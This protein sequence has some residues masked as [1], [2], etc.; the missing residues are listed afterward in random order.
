MT[1]ES[2]YLLTALRQWHKELG[3]QETPYELPIGL[4]GYGLQ[5]TVHR[6]GSG[7]GLEWNSAEYDYEFRWDFDEKPQPNTGE[8]IIYNISDDTIRKMRIGDTLITFGGFDS[9]GGVGWFFCA[10]IAEIEA[11]WKGADRAVTLHLTQNAVNPNVLAHSTWYDQGA[12]ADIGAFGSG[13]PYIAC[14]YG[15][16]M[17]ASRIL[18]DLVEQCGYP[19]LELSCESDR[20]YGEAV[21]VEGPLY[22][23]IAEF[24][25]VCGSTAY[26]AN[27]LLVVKNLGV[28]RAADRLLI[29]QQSGL[30]E[31]PTPFS[32]ES[33]AE[34]GPS[35]RGYKVKLLGNQRVQIGAPV[36]LQSRYV[37]APFTVLRGSHSYD[38]K[39]LLTQAVLVE[40][41]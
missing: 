40:S 14:T 2:S 36:L 25:A 24:A 11:E 6:A 13:G 32:E 17:R 23:K 38:G 27:G 28:N 29:S 21:V 5:A 9:G 1:G 35:Y 18:G 34:G 41:G 3:E 39:N 20:V 15:A 33:A 22:E 37:N 10:D 26:L 31:A 12:G 7:I 4:Y 16:G 8:F 30:I 19:V